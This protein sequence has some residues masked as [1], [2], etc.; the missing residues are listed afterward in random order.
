MNITGKV[1]CVAVAI[2]LA[3]IE[4]NAAI[5]FGPDM[6]DLTVFSKTYT[7]TG[8][9]ST[10]FGNVLAGDVSTIGA[11]GKV[12]GRLVSVGAGNTGGA[13]SSVSGDFVSGGV[14][15][16]GDGSTIGGSIMSSG[17]ATIGAG[18]RVAGDMTSG[19]AATTGDSSRV[20]GDLKSGGAA[21]TGANSTV[22]GD[23]AAVGLISIGANSLVGSQH[24]LMASPLAPLGLTASLEALVTSLALQVSSAQGALS[25]MVSTFL[26]APTITTDRTLVSGVYSAASLST[27]A[28]TTLT[29]D[30]QGLEDQY[31]VFNIADIL[32][33]GASTNIVMINAGKNSAVVW[34][35]GGYASLGANSTFLGEI[36]AQTYVSVGAHTDVAGVGGACGAIFSATSYVSLGDTATVGGKGCSGLGSGFAVGDDGAAYHVNTPVLSPLDAAA[37]PEPG[38]WGLMI[39]GF[40]LVGAV[41]RRQRAAAFA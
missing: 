1:A 21:S 40:G 36:L 10:V 14:L 22:V 15:T 35:T 19:G 37:V 9:N 12:I 6:Q 27:T 30:G 7:T 18:S 5:L 26:L 38:V 29:L 41:L 8:A 4:S 32:A 16:T 13:S 23:V 25:K 24:A 28:G 2:C 31:W 39:V 33:T 11:N 20:G 3:P 17:A 34:N